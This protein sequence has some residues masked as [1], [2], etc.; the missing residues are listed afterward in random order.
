MVPAGMIELDESH[1][2]LGQSPR[3]E[4]VRGECSRRLGLVAVEFERGG[5]LL[6]EVHHLGNAR[7]HSIGHLV[8]SH[9]RGDLGIADIL[10]LRRV[11]FREAVEHSA[12]ARRADAVRVLQVQ[13]RIAPAA[14]LHSLMH[15]RQEAV[16]P[17]TRIERLVDPVFRDQHDEPRQVFVR[18]AEAIRQPRSHAGTAREVMSR[19][20]ERDRRIVV[21]VFGVERLQEAKLIRHLARPR[22]KFAEPRPRLPMLSELERRSRQWQRRLKARHAG[23]SLPLAHA[24]GQLLSVHRVE[25]RLV[26]EQV[27]L[28]RP[29]TH[30]ERDDSLGLRR[31]VRLVENASKQF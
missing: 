28:R 30:D 16:S 4:T 19:L 8:L 7:L 1:V 23:Q 13:H 9:P 29:A 14:E 6:R 26:V 17:Q 11:Q 15:A 2:P 20:D 24:V 31:E 12:T 21:D 18:A 5:R 25:Q 22:Q 3:E 27:Q 10:E